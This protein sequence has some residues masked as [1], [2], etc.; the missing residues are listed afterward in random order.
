MD[1]WAV[2]DP[3]RERRPPCAC[4]LRRPCDLAAHPRALSPLGVRRTNGN[5]ELI[6]VSE[7]DRLPG[8]TAPPVEGL[9]AVRSVGALRDAVLRRARRRGRR[10]DRGRAARRATTSRSRQF[11]WA[12]VGNLWVAEKHRRR[13]IASW[14]LGIAADWLRLGGIERLLDLRLARAGG[15]ARVRS[16]TTAS[17]SSSAPSAAGSRQYA[18]ETESRARRRARS[19][20]FFRRAAD[21]TSALRARRGRGRASS[22]TRGGGHPSRRRTRSRSPPGTGDSAGSPEPVV[23]E[24]GPDGIRH[25]GAAEAVDVDLR[26]VLEPDHRIRDP[27]GARH[28]PLV[29]RRPA[30]TAHGRGP[31]SRR[32]PRC[33]RC[34]PGRRAGP[35]RPRCAACLATI[36]PVSCSTSMSATQHVIVFE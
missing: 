11:G 24:P 7:L 23:R 4:E 27:V 29:E 6:L 8:T 10:P 18:L 17:A 19:H 25:V 34:R 30:R 28:A 20:R 32:L 2:R 35:G 3:V 5:L 12:D 31:A 15:R 13:G 26:S 9:T 14:L 33:S 1:G 16:P 21:A 36:L 22:A